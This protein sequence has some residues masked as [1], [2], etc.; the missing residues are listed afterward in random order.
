VVVGVGSGGWEFVRRMVA[1]DDRIEAEDVRGKEEGQGM[2]VQ[3]VAGLSNKCMQ[4]TR[5]GVT[6]L[7]GQGPR[8]LACS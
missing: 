4:L 2:G 6:A 8:R 1:Q 3:T 5:R 7:A